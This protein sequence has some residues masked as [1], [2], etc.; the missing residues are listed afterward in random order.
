MLAAP[1]P[2][3]SGFLRRPERL[4]VAFYSANIGEK[5]RIREGDESL[6]NNANDDIATYVR[7][8]QREHYDFLVAPRGDPIYDAATGGGYEER[9]RVLFFLRPLASD[10][11]AS[12]TFPWSSGEELRLFD[13]FNFDAVGKV[14]VDATSQHRRAQRLDATGYVEVTLMDVIR[15]DYW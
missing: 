11:G 7:L 15:S 12:D 4:L 8:V 9:R 14:R 10:G 3:K 5:E 2:T 6:M 1:V 13:G